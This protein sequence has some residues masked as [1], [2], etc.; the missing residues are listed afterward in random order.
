MTEEL[1]E[2]IAVIE[3]CDLLGIKVFHIPNEGKRSSRYGNLLKRAGM[4]PG[5]PDLFFPKPSNGYHGLFIEMKTRSG[6]ASKEQREWIQILNDSGYLAKVCHGF[7]EAVWVIR[8]YF[9][10]E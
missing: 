3:Y 10:K 2:Q 5:V 6:K 7:D 1:D 4:R 8:T 9:K